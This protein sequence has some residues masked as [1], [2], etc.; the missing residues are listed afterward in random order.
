MAV[1]VTGGAGFIGSHLVEALLERGDEVF[2]V[3]D[4]STG[5][6]KNLDHLRSNARL[7]V[8]VGKVED[9]AVL[10][11]LVDRV[12]VVYHLAGAV[13]P[14]LVVEAPV[15]TLES[16]LRA[17]QVV[18]EH[19]ARRKKSVFFASTADVY[20]KPTP[21]EGGLCREDQD[22]ALGPPESPRWSYGCA[23]AAAEVLALAYARERGLPV[24]VARLFGT[25]G[26]RQ[27]A[28]YGMV[29]P[30]FV[31]QALAGEPLTVHG[32]GSQVRSFAFVGDVVA[33]ALGLV[34]THTAYGK[35]VNVGSDEEITLADLAA[36]IVSFAG[37]DSV[38]EVGSGVEEVQ[39][40]IPD[41]TRLRA[42]VGE[43]P[44]ITL[45]ESLR[46]AIAYVKS[47]G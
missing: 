21:T 45:D 24:I 20:G 31:R 22:L 9:S 14:R 7:H 29:V 8:T 27:N 34:E 2:V 5:S 13:G 35:V 3:D 40:R 44:R 28:R 43:L 18:F 42:L 46:R 1:L 19:A 33:A 47:L 10:A 37:S 38:I 11:G 30:T 36:R 41:L 4:L 6:I 12:A 39:R 25:I 17:A 32:D 23:R 16:N 26:P 15:R